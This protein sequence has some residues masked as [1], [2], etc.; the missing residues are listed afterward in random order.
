LEAKAQ[1]IVAG[2]QRPKGFEGTDELA[3]DIKKTMMLLIAECNADMMP[4]L[5]IRGTTCQDEGNVKGNL[6]V[7]F[8]P[9]PSRASGVDRKKDRILFQSKRKMFLL[10]DN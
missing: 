1:V 10:L 3:V 9:N 4:R 8:L 7:R 6:S 5:V 2:N